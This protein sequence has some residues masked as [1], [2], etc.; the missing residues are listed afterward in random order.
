MTLLLLLVFIYYSFFYYFRLFDFL[1]NFIFYFYVIIFIFFA[2]EIKK[3]SFQLSIK[4][5]ACH[6][7]STLFSFFHIFHIFHIFIFYSNPGKGWKSVFST[8]DRVEAQRK[9]IERGNTAE[10]VEINGITYMKSILPTVPAIRLDKRSGRKVLFNTIVVFF[11]VYTQGNLY[12]L[13]EPLVNKPLFLFVVSFYEYLFL[14]FIARY[15][16]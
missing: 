12:G 15:I 4:K 6:N 16:L 5:R 10:W 3:R 8:S 9:C 11:I 1:F 13:I 14:S 2:L 7:I